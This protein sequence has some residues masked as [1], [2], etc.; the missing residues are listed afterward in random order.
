[1]L[2][3]MLIGVTAAALV[4]FGWA[5]SQLRWLG[6]QCNQQIAYWRHEAERAVA[7]AAWVREQQWRSEQYWLHARPAADRWDPRTDNGEGGSSGT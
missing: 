4:V 5:A 1:M 6:A 3:G 2:A 7:A